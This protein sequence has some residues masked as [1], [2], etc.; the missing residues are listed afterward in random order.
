MLSARNPLLAEGQSA[1]FSKKGNQMAQDNIRQRLKLVYGI[2]GAF[3]INDTKD[4][5]TVSLSIP[6]DVNK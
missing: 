4:N 1:S 3:S 5:Y 2:K 6:L